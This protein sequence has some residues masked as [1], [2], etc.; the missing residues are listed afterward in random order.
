[1]PSQTNP[2]LVRWLITTLSVLVAA[3]IVSGIAYDTFGTLLVAALLLGILNAVF[4]PVLLLLSLPLLIVSLGFF[5]L[6]INAMLL[7][8]VGWLVGPFHVDSFG[9]AFWGGVVISLVSMTV[10][11][12][13]GTR[14]PNIR[15]NIHLSRRRTPPPPGKNGGPS[16]PVID[17]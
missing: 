16:G 14:N 12:L 17:V 11:M 15:S 7:Y 3:N 13:C 5:V 8:F 10:N 9:A 2:F 4:R 1:M 6:V